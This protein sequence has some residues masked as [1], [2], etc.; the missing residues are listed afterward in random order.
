VL[1]SHNEAIELKAD[2][3]PVAYH[4]V[5]DPFSQEE[6]QLTKGDCIYIFSDGFQD[7]IGG[8]N[9][10]KFMKK[11]MRQLLLDIHQKPFSEQ[12]DLLDKTIED[13]K[14]HPGGKTDQMDDI[15]VIG[16]RV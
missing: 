11:N 4:I 6:V 12:R 13:W 2:R 7:Q 15:L 9:A 8:P 14:N 5:M 16:F 3:M 10:R 1:I